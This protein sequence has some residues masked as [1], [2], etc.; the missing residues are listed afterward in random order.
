MAKVT[1]D[2]MVKMGLGTLLVAKD[3]VE[4]FVN[5]AVKQ[6]DVSKE[7]GSR[8]LEEL[9]KDMANRGDEVQKGLQ[10]EIHKALKSLGVATKEDLAALRHEITALKHEIQKK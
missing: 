4:E 1:L 7:E 3:R 6:G 8:F 10:N 9:K 5:D 2:D